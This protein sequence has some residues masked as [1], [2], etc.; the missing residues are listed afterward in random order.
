MFGFGSA[1]RAGLAEL[2][3]RIVQAAAR[4]PSIKRVL[5]WGSSVT[6]KPT[7]NDLDYS[8]IVGVDHVEG[9]VTDEHRRFLEPTAAR[10]YYGRDRGYLVIRD[11][12]IG[13]YCEKLDFLTTTRNGTPVGIVEMQPYGEYIHGDE[14]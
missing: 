11:H 14:A 12:P 4:Y 1:K 6:S 7:P 10:I 5:I 2:L 3:R 9:A 8:I 13:K